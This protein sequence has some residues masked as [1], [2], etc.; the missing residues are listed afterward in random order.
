MYLIIIADVY[1]LLFKIM[2]SSLWAHTLNQINKFKVS[3]NR[4]AE[5]IATA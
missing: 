4:S 2:T 5:D 1:G 3:K